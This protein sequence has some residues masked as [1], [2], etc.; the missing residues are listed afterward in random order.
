LQAWAI[1]LRVRTG[2]VDF[3]RKVALATTRLATALDAACQRDADFRF[4]VRDAMATSCGAGARQRGLETLLRHGAG[5]R[6]LQGAAPGADEQGAIDDQRLARH[7]RRLVARQEEST[8]RIF[9]S[10]ESACSGGASSACRWM[11]VAMPPG[12]IAF[13][14]TLY[15]PSSAATERVRLMTAAFNAE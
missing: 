2:P 3:I 11:G 1:L 4:A 15:G 14:R 9:S 6:C 13:T 8:G 12:Q 7:E 5:D 10:S